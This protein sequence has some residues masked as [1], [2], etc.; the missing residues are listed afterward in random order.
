MEDKQDKSFSLLSEK[1]RSIVGQIPSTLTRYNI[2]IIF[3]IILIIIGISFFLPY[4]QTV[5]G[6]AFITERYVIIGD[7]VLVDA[8]LK[9]Q[10]ESSITSFSNKIIL[11]GPF[12]TYRGRLVEYSPYRK[13]NTK[14]NAIIKLSISDLN[15]IQQKE[16]DSRLI[17]FESTYFYH[18]WNAF[19]NT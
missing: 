4:R 15:D 12:K 3:T 2:I 17:I 19:T 18:F 13:A 5:S 10:K 8:V 7:S 9:V 14:S 6:S 1:A 16:F 11:I